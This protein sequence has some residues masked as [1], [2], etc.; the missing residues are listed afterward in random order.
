MKLGLSDTP[1]LLLVGTKAEIA[2][3]KPGKMKPEQLVNTNQK[4]LITSINN[5]TVDTYGTTETTIQF[6][7]SKEI[8]HNFQVVQQEFPEAAGDLL[9]RDSFIKCH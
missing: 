7:S 5:H 3:L 2:I 4:C 8:E 6:D 9:G 1:N